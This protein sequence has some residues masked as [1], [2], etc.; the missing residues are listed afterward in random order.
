MRNLD[1]Y[2]V[3]FNLVKSTLTYAYVAAATD[4]IDAV[5]ACL[6]CLKDD[7]KRDNQWD[8]GESD[9]VNFDSWLIIGIDRLHAGI[10]A[11]SKKARP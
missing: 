5:G 1:L 8:E 11:I 3:T 6:P 4:A 9:K 7:C 10:D 2:R